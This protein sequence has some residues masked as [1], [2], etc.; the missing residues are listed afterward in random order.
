MT[1][2]VWL[3]IFSIILFYIIIKKIINFE[4]SFDE[5]LF[6]EK[7]YNYKKLKKKLNLD[8]LKKNIPSITSYFLG[9]SNI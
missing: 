5:T 2:N 9:L 3:L 6:I 4:K 1:F 8:N 7:Y